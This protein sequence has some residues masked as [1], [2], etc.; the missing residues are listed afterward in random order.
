M[1]WNL[2]RLWGR[3]LAGA[4]LCWAL[5]CSPV[6]GQAIAPSQS[7]SSSTTPSSSSPSSDDDTTQGTSAKS[8]DSTPSSSSTSKSKSTSD[9]PRSSSSATRPT[10]DSTRSGSTS[11]S[12]DTSRS[13]SQPRSSGVFDQD[14]SDTTRSGRQS[15]DDAR[16]G[17][18]DTLKETRDSAR[19]ATRED[20]D[21]DDFRSSRQSSRSSGQ[22]GQSSQRS[23][24]SR[25]S[26]EFDDLHG[27]AQPRSTRDSSRD[28]ARDTARDSDDFRS[29]RD[30]ARDQKGDR[31]DSSRDRDEARDDPRDSRSQRDLSQRDDRSRD[32]RDF[33]RDDRDFNRD[34]RADYQDS[35][36]DSRDDFRSTSR[37]SYSESR[38]SDVDFRVEDVR[39]A[40]IG[41]WFNR[42]S[43]D[44]LV[45]SDVSSSGAITRFGFRE[46]DQI[47][48]V[49][50]WRVHDEPTFI[51]YLFDPEIRNQRVEVIVWRGGRQTTVYVQP[52]LLIQEYTSAA[53]QS[54]PLEEYGLVLDDRYPNYIVVWKVL[55]RTPAFYAGI[56]AGDTI[57]SWDGYR[58]STPQ[59][60]T[61]YVQRGWSGPIDLQVSRNRQMRQL[62]LDMDQ[63]TRRTAL[64]PNV[65]TDARG[66]V[67]VDRLLPGREGRIE[68]RIERREDFR[69]GS[70]GTQGGYQ[71]QG[72]TYSTPTYGTQ[73]TFQAQ[74]GVQIYGQGTLQGQPGVQAGAEVRPGLLPRA[75]GR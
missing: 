37:A 75:R 24:S 31:R 53:S 47:V 64:R 6:L 21:Q 56:R 43:R 39:S 70:Y 42:S 9:Q 10:P 73:G 32:D 49:N 14:S 57:V 40:D 17:P 33:R 11:R 2:L 34:Q 68:N 38:S 55:P 29:S 52:S 59:Q 62:Q 27:G 5:S 48:S 54:D 63:G 44:G 20:D 28:S 60:F 41:L 19:D 1:R 36:R 30:S 61:S 12:G 13:S 45:I 66:N 3:L 35:R 25:S 4:S 22:T 23:S 8:S 65:R 67:D 69:D 71:L 18:R 72:G 51:E 7:S 74:P 15:Y 26:E 58:V 16:S 50:G 46:A